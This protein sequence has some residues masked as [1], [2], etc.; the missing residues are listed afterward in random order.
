LSARFRISPAFY[1]RRL[2]QPDLNNDSPNPD[3]RALEIRAARF[4]LSGKKI[5]SKW[6]A[7]KTVI[8]DIHHE[9][10]ELQPRK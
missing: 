9:S 2:N 5:R 7:R 8:D 6:F 3:N 10:R 1:D 4:S